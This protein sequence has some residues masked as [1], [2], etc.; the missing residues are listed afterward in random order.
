[1]FTKIAFWPLRCVFEPPSKALFWQSNHPI[2]AHAG[3]GAESR[4]K[5]R[6]RRMVTSA[7]EMAL[8]SPES[9]SEGSPALSL[10]GRASAVA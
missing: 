2:G 1:M 10:S 3:K 5:R 6:R 8:R 9:L 4:S 7:T